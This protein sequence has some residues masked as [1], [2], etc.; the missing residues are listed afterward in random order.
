[1]AFADSVGTKETGLFFQELL[2]QAFPGPINN[3][4]PGR[5]F[6]WEKIEVK[7]LIFK[8]Y[9]ELLKYFQKNL[10]KESMDAFVKYNKDVFK[11]YEQKKQ[12]TIKIEYLSD[13]E[14]SKDKVDNI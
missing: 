12:R 2:L 11:L 3:E 6:T 8:S 1:M 5:V 9:I 10:G 13:K 14:T 7:L 4:S